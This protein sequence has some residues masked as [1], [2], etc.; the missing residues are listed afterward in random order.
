MIK[1]HSQFLQNHS[2]KIAL[3]KYMRSSLY[4]RIKKYTSTRTQ[5]STH[6]NTI[7]SKNFVFYAQPYEAL[8]LKRNFP[9]PQLHRPPICIVGLLL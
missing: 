9:L 6:Q 3:T 2:E 7:P 4:L 1:L 8:N 5:K